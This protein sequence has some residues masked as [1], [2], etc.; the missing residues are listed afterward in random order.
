MCRLFIN[1]VLL[2]NPFKSKER[3]A[4]T[5]FMPAKFH[6]VLARAEFSCFF[7]DSTQCYTRRVRLHAALASAESD[8]MLC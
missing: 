7:V 6:S 2:D 8:S 5:N 3:P 4:K 1:L